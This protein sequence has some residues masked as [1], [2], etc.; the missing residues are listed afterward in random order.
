MTWKSHD[1]VL[2][3][4]GDLSTAASDAVELVECRTQAPRR[5]PRHAVDVISDRQWQLLRAHM[6]IGDDVSRLEFWEAFYAN[7]PV[8]QLPD[9]DRIL[10]LQPD[11]DCPAAGSRE[12]AD[13]LCSIANTIFGYRLLFFRFIT[14]NKHH[15]KLTI[16]ELRWAANVWLDTKIF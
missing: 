6:R 11:V 8:G 12:E 13:E 5:R 9:V 16:H 7:H 15:C 14:R 1:D 4:S 2:P 3:V 10:S